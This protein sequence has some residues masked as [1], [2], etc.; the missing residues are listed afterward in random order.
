M[1]RTQPTGAPATPVA[2]EA[3]PAGQRT[4]DTPMPPALGLAVLD[5]GTAA[6]ALV[7]V[8]A[9]T[10]CVVARQGRG[11][12]A[13][14]RAACSRGADETQPQ[15]IPS[16]RS[17]SIVRLGGTRVGVPLGN[18]QPAPALPVGVVLWSASS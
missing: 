5:D 7:P 1:V 9:S 4:D 15:V 2:V 17:P 16:G 3:G 14:G 13:L 6:V 18:S 10:T 11:G 8:S 12:E